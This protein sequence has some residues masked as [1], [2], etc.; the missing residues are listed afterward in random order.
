MRNDKQLRQWFPQS[1]RGHSWV[2]V[3]AV[4]PGTIATLKS[5][6]SIDLGGQVLGEDIFGPN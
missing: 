4:L 6:V 2:A 1:I 5:E 3:W